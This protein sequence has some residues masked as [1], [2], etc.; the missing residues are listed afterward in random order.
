MKTNNIII[1]MAAIVIPSFQNK[2]PF[3]LFTWL[4]FILLIH[5]LISGYYTVYFE[6]LGSVIGINAEFWNVTELSII[7]D[8]FILWITFLI[9]LYLPLIFYLNNRN[10]K[11]ETLT[12][13]TVKNNSAIKEKNLSSHKVDKA[14]G[15]YILN[16][17]Y[18]IILFSMLLIFSFSIYS[19]DLLTFVV[20]GQNELIYL[21]TYIV[22]YLFFNFVYNGL[23][24]SDNIYEAYAQKFLILIIILIFI[25]YIIY[26]YDINIINTVHCCSNDE[27]IKDTVINATQNP[28]LGINNSMSVS[29]NSVNKIVDSTSSIIKDALLPFANNL[30]IAGAMGGLATATASVLKKTPMTPASKVASVI[31]A[32]I[33]G[34]TSHLGTTTLQRRLLKY[35][36]LSEK[37]E[38]SSSQSNLSS[39][40]SNSSSSQLESSTSNQTSN[41]I[42]SEDFII[43][44]PNETFSTFST[45]KNDLYNYAD[46]HPV[47]VLLYSILV[48]NIISLFLIFNLAVALLY[49]YLANSKLELKFIDKLISAK[50]STTVKYYIKKVI[51]L[52]NRLNTLHIIFIILVIIFANII[53]I[54]LLS[55]YI[56]NLELISKIYLGIIK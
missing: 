51:H 9:L 40:Q 46:N 34:G 4:Y 35:E 53:S 33:I 55:G 44:S 24:F 23:Q 12:T 42:K 16:T 39:S 15:I 47:D 6:S 14:K 20:V 36:R 32:G 21:I 11:I 43:P 7:L 38:S 1:L 49:K 27:I 41:P 48:L 56:N 18:F 2:L 28:N 26:E 37:S 3:F 52:S 19:S 5:T 10:S 31:A 8:L 17:Y 50:Y 54:Y 29:E 30:G 22:F 25:T 45:L 13:I